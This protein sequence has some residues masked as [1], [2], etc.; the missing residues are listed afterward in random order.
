MYFEVLFFIDCISSESLFLLFGFFVIFHV[1][2]FN[3]WRFIVYLY[4]KEST[5]KPLGS[6]SLSDFF[7]KCIGISRH[8]SMNAEANS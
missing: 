7:Q 6:L 1:R 2:N 4:L 5:K 8:G 3:I